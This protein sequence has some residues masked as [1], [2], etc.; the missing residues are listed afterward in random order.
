MKLKLAVAMLVLTQFTVADESGSDKTRAS[1]QS[2]TQSNESAATVDETILRT[3]AALK[4]FKESYSQSPSNRAFA[5]SP[6]G[7]W[8]WRSDR[9]TLEQAQED[10]LASCNK[11]VRKNERECVIININGEWIKPQQ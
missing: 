10:A 5:Q 2:R 7:H 9:V 3:N 8:N 6:E 4:S 11:H 1:V